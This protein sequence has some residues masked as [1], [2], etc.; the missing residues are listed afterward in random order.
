MHLIF[1]LFGIWILFRVLGENDGAEFVGNLIIGVIVFFIAAIV[2]FMY[3]MSRILGN[4]Y[5]SRQ[6]SSPKPSGEVYESD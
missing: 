6:S 2:L 4:W 1:L 5:E 3:G